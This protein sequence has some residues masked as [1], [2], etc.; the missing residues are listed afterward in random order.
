M[1]KIR[2][3]F[4]K[5]FATSRITIEETD[6]FIGNKKEIPAKEWKL[7]F[8]I[9]RD[10]RGI[11]LEYY[12]TSIRDV[13]VHVRIYDNGNEEILDILK[14]YVAYHPNIPGDFERA[15]GEFKIHNQRI[16]DSLREK[17]LI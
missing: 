11:F 4:S 8:I 10:E 2:E 6:I 16:L 14:E 15:V 1:C 9:D 7:K 5:R 13:H 12:G 17:Q 3:T